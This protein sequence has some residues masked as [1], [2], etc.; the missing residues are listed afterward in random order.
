MKNEV[1][2]IESTAVEL[3]NESTGEVIDLPLFLRQ[4]NT[5]GA[6]ILPEK[7]FDVR[8]MLKDGMCHF[9]ISGV[10]NEG[11]ELELFLINVREIKNIRPSAQYER[12]ADFTQ[13]LCFG[14][15]GQIKTFFCL[16]VGGVSAQ[17]TAEFVPILLAKGGPWANVVRLKIE[18]ET[19]AKKQGFGV[20]KLD[21]RDATKGEIEEFQN[22]LKIAPKAMFVF[23]DI[24]DITPDAV[25]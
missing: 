9:S 7:P 14:R 1:A 11:A 16:T 10:T 23:N 25:K 22:A 3:V 18:R 2:T 12:G 4:Q 15:V 20:V 19:N 5:T 6:V 21:L 17:K 13:L 24:Q 8:A